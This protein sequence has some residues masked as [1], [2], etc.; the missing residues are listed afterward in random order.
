MKNKTFNRA[1]VTESESVWI[2]GL[3]KQVGARAQALAS[4]APPRPR[5]PHSPTLGPKAESDSSECFAIPSFHFFVSSV[6]PQAKFRGKWGDQQVL[7][8]HQSYQLRQY[9]GCCLCPWHFHG[10]FLGYLRATCAR[11]PHTPTSTPIFPA[12]GRH[13]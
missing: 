5:P 12:G 13:S 2:P 9:C 7:S 3:P 11:A 1:V 4:V 8:S 10:I 6:F